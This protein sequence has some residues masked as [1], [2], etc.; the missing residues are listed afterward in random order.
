MTTGEAIK[1]KL[2]VDIPLEFLCKIPSINDKISYN[3]VSLIN[4]D[5]DSLD[6]GHYV[7]DIFSTNTGFWW[8][9]DYDNITQIGDLL[10]GVY[11]RE[12]HKKV[13]SGSTDVLFVVYIRTSYLIN[14]SSIFFQEFANMSKI[15]HMK[16]LI[17]DLNVFRKYFRVRQEVG[18]EIKTSFFLVKMSFKLP[19]KLIYLVKKKRKIIFVEWG[20]NKKICSL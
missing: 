19:L 15:N 12:S 10:K 17:E 2:E 13:I 6:Y 16:K 14:S 11:I 8:N 1:N 20:W 9:C 5:G 4:H 3:L 7:S 18:D